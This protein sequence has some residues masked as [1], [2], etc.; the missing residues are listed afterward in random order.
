MELRGAEKLVPLAL[1][2]LYE[3]EV[4]QIKL[5]KEAGVLQLTFLQSPAGEQF[6]NAYRLALDLAATKGVRFW[7]TDARQIKAMLPENQTWLVQ[8]MAPL[9]S[10]F[11]LRRFAI[12]MAPECFVMTNPTRVYEKPAG[13]E[14]ASARPIKVHFDKEAA[15]QWLLE[16]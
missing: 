9:F 10:S 11:Q 3:D 14:P 4:A 12:V 13:Q 15:F 16:E 8:N 2:N 7:L 6:R 5:D 1:E